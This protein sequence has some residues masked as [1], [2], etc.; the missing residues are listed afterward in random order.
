MSWADGD[1]PYPSEWEGNS[2]HSAPATPELHREAPSGHIH[3]HTVPVT[4]MPQLSLASNSLP[5]TFM[6][7]S[8]NLAAPNIRLAPST[9]LP[10]GS[11]GSHS[12]CLGQYAS[13]FGLIVGLSGLFQILA[14][15]MAIFQAQGQEVKE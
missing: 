8:S 11:S 9:L 2:Q 15:P 6:G 1:S 5:Q 3:P 4:P 14:S 12:I 7:P 13:P 10:L